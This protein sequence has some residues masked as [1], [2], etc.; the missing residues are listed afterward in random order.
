M[1]GIRAVVAG[2]GAGVAAEAGGAGVTLVDRAVEDEADCRM[3]DE[4][5][6]AV[7]AAVPDTKPTNSG[8]SCVT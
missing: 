5:D 8:K 2:S 3:G 6:T 7:E 1:R 4:A